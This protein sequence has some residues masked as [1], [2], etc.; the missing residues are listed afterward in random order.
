MV[1]AGPPAVAVAT[2]MHAAE[3]Q[4]RREINGDPAERWQRK[5]APQ[6]RA[7]SHLTT[8]LRG[9]YA[10]GRTAHQLRMVKERKKTDNPREGWEDGTPP[11]HRGI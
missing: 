7:G 2:G 10:I 11:P 9:F 4:S 6:A 8:H 1:V 3:C 5:L